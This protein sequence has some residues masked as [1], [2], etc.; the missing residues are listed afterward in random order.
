MTS[1]SKQL[2]VHVMGFKTREHA[3]HA[4]DPIKEV[5]VTVHYVHAANHPSRPHLSRL[6]GAVHLP[7][8]PRTYPEEPGEEQ[9]YV[10]GLDTAISGP[11]I[12]ASFASV[13][14]L[15]STTSPLCNWPRDLGKRSR[16]T[17]ACARP[18][19]NCKRQALPLVLL[20][21]CSDRRRG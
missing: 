1:M 14:P 10:R 2:N 20:M 19:S 15:P 3:E 5:V 16:T 7:R 18:K 4:R 17:H 21:G 9:C 11:W 12:C 6:P 8:M 13:I